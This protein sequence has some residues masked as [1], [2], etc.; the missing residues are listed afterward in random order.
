MSK[1][2]RIWDFEGSN[3]KMNVWSSHLLLSN[4]PN[5]RKNGP[6]K[7]YYRVPVKKE[8]LTGTVP[9]NKELLTG[10]VPVNNLILNKI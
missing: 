8:L 9:V 2:V 7:Q 3:S 4:N 1:G 5:P 6:H 10:T